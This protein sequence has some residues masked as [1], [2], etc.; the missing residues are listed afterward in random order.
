[1]PNLGMHELIDCREILKE[2][3]YEHVNNNCATSLEHNFYDKAIFSNMFLMIYKKNN[4]FENNFVRI[5]HKQVHLL[6]TNNGKM[7]SS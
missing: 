3:D 2:F 5:L 1:M 4:N 7:R 6:F